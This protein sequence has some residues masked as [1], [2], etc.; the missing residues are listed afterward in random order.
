MVAPRPA[1]QGRGPTVPVCWDGVD[2]KHARLSVPDQTSPRQAG[3][4]PTE[5]A[6]RS[7]FSRRILPREDPGKQ[8]RDKW[9]LS[10]HITGNP[11]KSIYSAVRLGQG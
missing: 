11:R 1:T 10:R 7:N 9:G 8:V 6:T 5:L 4:R 3:T 2:P